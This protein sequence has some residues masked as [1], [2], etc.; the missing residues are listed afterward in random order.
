MEF[1]R[2][3]ICHTFL[4]LSFCAKNEET[5]F[6]RSPLTAIEHVMDSSEKQARIFG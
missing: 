3:K 2:T 5:S 1:T 6:P 4:Y